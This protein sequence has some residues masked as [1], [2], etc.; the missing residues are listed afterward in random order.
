MCNDFR[1]VVRIKLLLS[2]CLGR[3]GLHGAVELTV[4]EN[5]EFLEDLSLG[6]WAPSR[7]GEPCGVRPI[8]KSDIPV[9]GTR[10]MT[11]A[12]EGGA[13]A[14]AGIAVVETAAW[15]VSAELEGTDAAV[16]WRCS[17]S[18]G[19]SCAAWGRKVCVQEGASASQRKP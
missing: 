2:V 11:V 19:G 5:A 14:Q 1:A 9:G 4:S 3:A 15:G 17:D 18:G 16:G 7:H 10:H 13:R 8:Y 12:Y 6:W